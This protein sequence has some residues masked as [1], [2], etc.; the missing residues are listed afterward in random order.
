M[1]A[2]AAGTFGRLKGKLFKLVG[3]FIGTGRRELFCGRGTLPREI[4]L[5]RCCCC[6]CR[7][8]LGG[9]CP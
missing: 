2:V 3:G 4:W 6:C 1:T 8:G 7:G 9:I 5:K